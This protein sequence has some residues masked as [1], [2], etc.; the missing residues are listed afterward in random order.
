MAY[1]LAAF[2][3]PWPLAAEVAAAVGSVAVPLDR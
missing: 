1:L 3:A 2:L